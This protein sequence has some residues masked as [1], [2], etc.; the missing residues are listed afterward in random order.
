MAS[1]K[2][3]FRS[4]YKYQLASD[5][6]IK[7]KV[8]PKKEINTPFIQLNTKGF[9]IIKEGYA[10]DGTSGPVLDTD[11]NIR[12]SLVHDAFYQLM[13][14]RELTPRKAYKDKADKLFREMCKE[15]GVLSPI[16]QLYYEA[17]KRFGN[18]STDPKNEKPVLK[19][20]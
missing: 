16:A 9:L 19:A 4:G 12:A 20:P 11:H 2:I 5:Y 15:D 6:S 13:R 3:F 1:D 8:K 10:W 17:L 18:P 7:T 14:K